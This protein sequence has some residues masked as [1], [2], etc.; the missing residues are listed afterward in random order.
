MFVLLVVDESGLIHAT[1]ARI[2]RKVDATLR[3]SSGLALRSFDAFMNMTQTSAGPNKPKQDKIRKDYYDL[4]GIT[5]DP[6]DQS[7]SLECCVLTGRTGGGRKKALKLAHLVPASASEDILN[8]IKLPNDE[9]GVWSLRNVLLLSWNIE[10]YYDRKK[11]SFV[12]HPLQ[13]NMYMM[14]IWDQDIGKELIYDEAVD[15]IE[16]GDSTIGYYENR[17]LNLTMN[18][19]T[20]LEP[21]KRCLSYQMFVCFA[22][23]NLSADMAPDDFASHSDGSWVTTRE[24][25][26]VL[27]KSVEKVI[28]EETL[29]EQADGMD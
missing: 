23:T 5:E 19:G 21:F 12:P 28:D 17:C 26:L 18:N 9:H 22:S 27:R 1:L 3:T 16:S 25:L 15:E 11:L 2:E 8:T 20:I 29:G 7:K 6:N 10:H 24:D 13:Q 14:K 4:C